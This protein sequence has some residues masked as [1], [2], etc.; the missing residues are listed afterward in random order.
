MEER[1]RGER[2]WRGGEGMEGGRRK[3]NQ[4]HGT[5]IYSA[6]AERGGWRRKGMEELVGG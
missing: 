3:M 4:L 1:M 6:L 2:E 5:D